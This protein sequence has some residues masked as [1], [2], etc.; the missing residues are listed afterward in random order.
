[1]ATQIM[2]IKIVAIKIVAAE[3]RKLESAVH[4]FDPSGL[5]GNQ[6]ICN[7]FKMPIVRNPKKVPG[8]K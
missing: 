5:V 3:N 1:M 8:K 7:L 6:V 4:R 2:A